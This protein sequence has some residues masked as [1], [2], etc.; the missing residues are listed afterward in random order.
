MLITDYKFGSI[1]IDGREYT[2]DVEVRS[3]TEET[4]PWERTKS[5]VVDVEDVEKALDQNPDLIIIGD[6]HSS[7]A[8]ITDNAKKE[9]ERRKI[10]LIIKQTAEAV[11]KFNEEMAK[12][13]KRVIG[14]FHLTC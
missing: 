9:M 1:I 14:L 11:E 12:R 3:Q 8:K 13:E 10:E 7:V 2:H 6:G 5:H 4:L